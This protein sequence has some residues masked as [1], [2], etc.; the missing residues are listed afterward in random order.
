M[1]RKSEPKRLQGVPQGP[2]EVMEQDDT[3]V[4]D[5]V[6]DYPERPLDDPER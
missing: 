2:R 1:A 6:D 3:A 5:P 4:Y